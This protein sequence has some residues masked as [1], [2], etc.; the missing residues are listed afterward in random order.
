MPRQRLVS[1]DFLCDSKFMVDLSNKA[2][3]LYLI[4]FVNA[5]DKGFVGSTKEIIKSLE[6]NDFNS[7]TLELVKHN[8]NDALKELVDMGFI[9][10]FKNKYGGATHLIR[11]WYY[12]NRYYAKGWTNYKQY[13][14]LVKLI[15]GEYM[16]KS[17]LK[18]IDLDN[19]SE[20]EIESENEHVESGEKETSNN[21]NW[22]EMIS[23]LE[24]KNP[25][26]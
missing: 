12:H 22:D 3:L 17:E 1:C 9:Y 10:E 26:L 20:S 21:D 11:H 16:L 24:S 6:Q 25:E 5:D 13:L 2:K 7:E 8:F 14:K 19:D 23:D 18:E 4:M 15:D